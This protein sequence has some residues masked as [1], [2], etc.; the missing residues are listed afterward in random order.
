MTAF[1][2]T[3]PL[4]PLKQRTASLTHGLP[5]HHITICAT[6][7]PPARLSVLTSRNPLLPRLVP[8][9]RAAWRRAWL[10]LMSE[11]APSDPQGRYQRP[12]SNAPLSATANPGVVGNDESST[13]ESS[14]LLESVAESFASRADEAPMEVFLGMACPWCHRVALAAALF[15]V[16]TSVLRVR[17]LSAGGNGLWEIADSS[18]PVP[19]GVDDSALRL[20]KDVYLQTYPKYSG[21]FTA[22]LLVDVDR[23]EMLS[24]ES[25]DILALFDQGRFGARERKLSCGTATVCLRPRVTADQD[26][27]HGIDASE[28]AEWCERIHVNVNDGV[29]KCGFATSQLAYNEA[30]HALFSTLDEIEDV[31]SRQ[32]FLCSPRVVTEAD[33]RLF[34]TVLRLDAVYGPLFRACRKSVRAD[35]P[36][37]SAWLRDVYHLDGVSSTCD[38]EGTVH[39]YFANLFPLNAGGIV[40]ATPSVDLTPAPHRIDLG[41]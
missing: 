12:M 3:V 36:N 16:S 18:M 13:P 22:P 29:Y 19:N 21:R 14:T 2:P 9:A 32:R 37:L 27:A 39:N 40:P 25:G 4:V 10:L 38:I 34:P 33:V 31:L 20:L 30:Q 41:A 8:L 15:A 35:Y 17:R 23:D 24:N 6:K 11:L 5:R 7:T 26:D 28:V 1:A